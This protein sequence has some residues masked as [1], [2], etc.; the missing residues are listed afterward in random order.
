MKMILS[1]VVAKIQQLHTEGINIQLPQ[2]HGTKS[3]KAKVLMAV[4][5]L[6]AQ[7]SATKFLQFNRNYSCLYCHDNVPM[8][9][10]DRYSYQM[11][12]MNYGLISLLSSMQNKQRRKEDQYLVSR[13]SLIFHLV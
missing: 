13:A 2:F 5:D 10:I 6:P 3:V 8:S 4:F 12:S 9:C 1:D 11:S 7:A